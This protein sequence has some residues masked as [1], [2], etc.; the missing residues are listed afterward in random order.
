V[1]FRS[2]KWEYND[3]CSKSFSLEKPMVGFWCIWMSSNSSYSVAVTAVSD[4]SF[5]SSLH[6]T[7]GNPA[8]PGF[9]RIDYAPIRGGNVSVF[10]EFENFGANLSDWKFYVDLV[11]ENLSIIG[12][13]ETELRVD[14]N[15]LTS[16]RVPQEDFQLRI[17][18]QNGNGAIME[19]YEPELVT[20]ST[21]RLSFLGMNNESSLVTVERRSKNVAL[22]YT[23]ENLGDK[24]EDI[25][26]EIKDNWRM[27]NFSKVVTLDAREKFSENAFFY[28]HDVNKWLRDVDIVTLVA[29]SIESNASSQYA[30][31]NLYFL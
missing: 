4:I 8:H 24:R 15:L 9:V 19:R 20:V 10:T 2:A 23:I 30:A 28:L 7:N 11:R 13:Y 29:Q 31:L 6:E 5:K 22:K 12:T 3:S 18:A 25:L 27:I 26:I 14:L 21:L 1:L 17:R 16:I